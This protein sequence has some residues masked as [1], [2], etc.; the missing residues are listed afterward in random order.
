MT[1]LA[2]ACLHMFTLVFASGW[3]WWVPGYSARVHTARLFH[4][5]CQSGPGRVV[6]GR[7]PSD[8]SEAHPG[9]PDADQGG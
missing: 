4:G 6:T 3:N 5:A 8:V 9:D 2:R 7:L 1:V